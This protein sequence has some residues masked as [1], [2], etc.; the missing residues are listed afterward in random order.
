MEVFV[1]SLCSTM[2]QLGSTKLV[3]NS[4]R[5]GLQGCGFELA[6]PTETF[7]ILSDGFS[8][9]ESQKCRYSLNKRWCADH[10]FGGWVGRCYVLHSDENY[11]FFTLMRYVR[12]HI[13]QLCAVVAVRENQQARGISSQYFPTASILQLVE[14][15]VVGKMED[16]SRSVMPALAPKLHQKLHEIKSGSTGFEAS[17]KDFGAIKIKE[18]SLPLGILRM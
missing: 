2:G 11:R 1:L 3:V 6:T 10:M 12:L 17:E 7:H 14:K 15:C 18:F 8:P 5:H 13:P 9:R 16:C 4:G